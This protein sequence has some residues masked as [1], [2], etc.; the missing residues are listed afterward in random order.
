MYLG[1]V[2]SATCPWDRGR[3]GSPIYHRPRLTMKDDGMPPNTPEGVLLRYHVAL[4]K[5][6]FY[7]N[8]DQVTQHMKVVSKGYRKC[9][10]TTRTKVTLQIRD[11]RTS[12]LTVKQ[13][14]TRPSWRDRGSGNKGFKVTRHMTQKINDISLLG[15]LQSQPPVIYCR[16]TTRIHDDISEMQWASWLPADIVANCKE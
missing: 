4:K 3:V 10:S 7:F 8:N 1:K 5:M 13:G 12:L 6:V 16:A 2:C 15:S 11:S 14:Q 9:H